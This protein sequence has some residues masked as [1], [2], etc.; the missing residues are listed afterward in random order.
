MVLLVIVGVTVMNK[1]FSAAYSFA[2]SE[3]IIS[4][5]FLFDSFRHFVFNDDIAEARVVLA[6][7]A[8][9]LIAAMSILIS[10]YLL[11]HCN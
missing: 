1:N 10:N 9:D 2:K 4:F 8:A 3:A 7:Q 6:D 11:Q 5:N